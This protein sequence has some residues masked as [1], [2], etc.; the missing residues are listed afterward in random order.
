MSDGVYTEKGISL[1]GAFLEKPLQVVIGDMEGILKGPGDMN[2]EWID[3]YWYGEH[4]ARFN[5]S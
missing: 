1:G 2:R 3:V 5:E 4:V